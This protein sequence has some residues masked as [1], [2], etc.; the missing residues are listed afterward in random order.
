MGVGFDTHYF[1]E[2]VCQPMVN[3]LSA[4]FNGRCFD[5]HYFSELVCQPMVNFLS[6]SFNGRWFNTHYFSENK[7]H[8]CRVFLFLVNN[9]ELPVVFA[10]SLSQLFLC[11]RC[12]PSMAYMSSLFPSATVLCYLI[13]IV[14]LLLSRPSDSLSL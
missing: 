1:S 4:S 3:F 14:K 2:L 9:D 12:S 6:A 10:T 7:I 13:L 11:C 8:I 5:T